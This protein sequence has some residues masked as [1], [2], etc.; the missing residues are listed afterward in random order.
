MA[1]TGLLGRRDGAA[2]LFG[3]ITGTIEPVRADQQHAANAGEGGRQRLRIV[4][5]GRADLDALGSQIL[6][7]LWLARRGDD[8]AGRHLQGGQQVADHGAAELASGTGHEESVG[9]C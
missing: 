1:D 2:M 9:H 4:E 6:Q 8:A 5:I 7:L 3:A